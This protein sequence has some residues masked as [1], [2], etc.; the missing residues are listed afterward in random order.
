MLDLGV[1]FRQAHAQSAKDKLRRL[2][3]ER[4]RAIA[5]HLDD[6]ADLARDRG[7]SV[8]RAV[9]R[10]LEATLEAAWLDP[11]AAA[12][13]KAGT[14]TTGLRY[15]GLGWPGAT[16]DPSLSAETSEPA[17]MVGRPDESD[18]GLPLADQALPLAAAEAQREAEAH[19]AEA[20]READEGKGRVEEAARDRDVWRRKVADLDQQ[21]GYAQEE[22][23]KAEHRFADA[24]QALVLA[25]QRL[26]AV[27]VSLDKMNSALKG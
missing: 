8:S 12:A 11:E 9:V 25:K 23:Q 24:E 7:E 4:R 10:D 14:L 2:Q 13:L 22:A 26:R 6:A 20:E 1:A 18:P 15:A 5:A 21:L 16:D 19:L 17:T 27:Q 3:R